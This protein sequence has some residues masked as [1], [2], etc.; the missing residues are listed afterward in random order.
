MKIIQTIKKMA[1]LPNKVAMGGAQMLL[2][3]MAGAALAFGFMG[4]YSSLSAKVVNDIATGFTA[5]SIPA[6]ISTATQTGLW[7]FANQFGTMGT[8][9]GITVVLAI[10]GLIGYG[11]YQMVKGR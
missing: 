5:S 1:V 3:G 11:G 7:N 8:V 10:V 4:I 6:N 2:M 9:L